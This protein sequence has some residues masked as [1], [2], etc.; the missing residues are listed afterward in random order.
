MNRN[1][2]SKRCGL[3]GV[4]LFGS[5]LAAPAQQENITA[6][7]SPQSYSTI[8][9]IGIEWR[10]QGDANHD[11]ACRVEYRKT[12]D[13]EWNEALPLVR[14]DTDRSNALTGSIFFLDPDTAYEVRL[15][16]TDPDGF[17]RTVTLS[18]HTRP[19]PALPTGGRTFHVVSGAAAGDG[20]EARPF[21]GIAAAE[22][23]A[24]PGDV[25]LLHAGDYG[26]VKLSKSGAPGRHVVWRAAGDGQVIVRGMSVR[27]WVWVEGLSFLTD[28]GAPILQNE[29]YLRHGHRTGLTTLE[30]GAGN[31]CVTRCTF[32]N[33]H[34]SIEL[35]R[36]CREWYIADNVIVGDNDPVTGGLGGEGVELNKT[37]GNVVAYNRISR[38]ADGIS[39]PGSDCDIYGNEIVDVSDDG[40]ETDMGQQNNRVWGNRI[41]NACNNVFSFQ[42]MNR[43]PW[44]FMRNQV[45]M[46][47]GIIWKFVTVNDR[48]VV[49]HNTFVFPQLAS[50]YAQCLLLSVSR[51]N[52]YIAYGNESP[53][54]RGQYH[55]RKPGQPGRGFTP[56]WMTDV[57]YDGFDWGRMSEPFRWD[58]KAYADLNR[59][60]A[61]VAIEKH[62]VRVRKEEIFENWATPVPGEA[63]TLVH[64][65][66]KEGCNAVDAGALLPNVNDDFAGRAPDLGALERGK[67]LPHYGPRS[68]PGIS[69]Q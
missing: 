11:A 8:H 51:N 61:A 17:H 10:I 6:A 31:V 24:R 5:C 25:F 56:D 26:V 54:L 45:V 68:Q 43:G 34:Y 30:R 65:T 50:Q 35:G 29:R 33:F 13:A 19:I 20:S 1:D 9:C 49:L 12:R 32:R 64:L 62:G 41:T 21:R 27:P 14:V 57:D 44:Y 37:H 36:G 69:S 59:F 58:G 7:G 16:L 3:L 66:L 23:A 15:G 52:L 39:Y 67:P 60:A 53:V 40:V 42:P 46:T 28:H 2:L 4:L 22:Q 63:P 55:P 18:E 38:V 48:F 47:R